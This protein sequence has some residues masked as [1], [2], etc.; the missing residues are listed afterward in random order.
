MARPDLSR[1]PEYFHE[2]IRKVKGDDLAE[3]FKTQFSEVIPFLEN[4]APE[5]T[6]YRYAEGK[7]SVKEVLQHIIDGERVFAY[8]ALCIARKD[9]TAFPGFKEN[10]YAENS[11]ADTRDWKDL[12]EEFRV[13]RRSSELLYGSFNNW[14]LESSGTVNGN[15]TYVLGIGFIIAGHVSHHINLLKERYL[16]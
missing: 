12:V 10:D 5:K 6:G 2:Y 15:S 13:V 11:A 7:W 14:Q 9:S 1:I 3:V 16:N 4:I 8:R